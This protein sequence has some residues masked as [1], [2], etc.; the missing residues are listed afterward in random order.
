[1]SEFENLVT[2]L[3]CKDLQLALEKAGRDRERQYYINFLTK[4][5]VVATAAVGGGCSDINVHVWKRHNLT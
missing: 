4:I 1:M 5:A 3:A 2:K